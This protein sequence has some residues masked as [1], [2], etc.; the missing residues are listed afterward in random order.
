MSNLR[1]LWS[2]DSEHLH[3]VLRGAEAL[4][5]DQ[6]QLVRMSGGKFSELGRL[7]AVELDH[8]VSHEPHR[9]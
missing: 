2:R 6:R 9:D 4:R 8:D 1:T 7:L 5:L 3:G